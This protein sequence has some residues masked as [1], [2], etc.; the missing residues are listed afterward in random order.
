MPVFPDAGVAPRVTAPA[1]V[2]PPGLDHEHHGSSPA[3]IHHDLCGS[4]GTMLPELQAVFPGRTLDLVR[5]AADALVHPEIPDV[6]P[7]V[8]RTH[9]VI[10]TDRLKTRCPAGVIGLLGGVRDRYLDGPSRDTVV[11]GW[12]RIFRQMTNDQRPIEDRTPDHRTAI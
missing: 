5:M 7:L 11:L 6:F 1:F 9:A 8:I 10:F 3:K 12:Q 4:H 2:L